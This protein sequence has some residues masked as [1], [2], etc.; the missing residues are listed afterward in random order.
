MFS[1][2]CIAVGLNLK[3]LALPRAALLLPVVIGAIYLWLAIRYWFRV[4]AIGI[5]LGTLCFAA[6]WAAY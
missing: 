6:A 4:P 5:A 2:G 3:A 1:G